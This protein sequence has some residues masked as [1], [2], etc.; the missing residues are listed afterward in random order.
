MEN[1]WSALT[2][3]QRNKLLSIVAILAALSISIVTCTNRDK[4]DDLPI[5]KA[6]VEELEQAYEDNEAGAQLKYGGRRVAVT[7]IV[8]TIHLDMTDDVV[9]QLQGMSAYSP[10]PM[11]ISYATKDKA[12]PIKKGQTITAI[13]RN[14][15]EELA[16]PQ[17]EDCDLQ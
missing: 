3:E 15:T 2:A 6:T 9:L 14:I 7:G 11:T 8:E 10:V 12:G 17:L 16:Q 1:K 5:I 4:S 13:C